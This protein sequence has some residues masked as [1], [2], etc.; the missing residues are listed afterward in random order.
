MPSPPQH[1]PEK[2]SGPAKK[3]IAGKKGIAGWVQR[4]DRAAGELNPF[5]MVLA[6]GLVVLNL[7]LYI[8]LAAADGGSPAA[9]RQPAAR[10]GAAY[11]NPA[12]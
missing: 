6:V 4:V 7:T 10:Y 2:S 3:T 5:L 9:A 11:A 1:P 8:G 12:P